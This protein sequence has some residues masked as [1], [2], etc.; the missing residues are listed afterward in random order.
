MNN[1]VLQEIQWNRGQ[2]YYPVSMR[3]FEAGMIKHF[4]G[5]ASTITVV[6]FSFLSP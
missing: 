3:K 6:S 5:N 2:V 1:E 4:P